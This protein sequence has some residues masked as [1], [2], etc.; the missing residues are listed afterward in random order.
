VKRHVTNPWPHTSRTASAVFASTDS[1]N[2]S[3]RSQVMALSNV[4]DNTPIATNVS[5]R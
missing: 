4:S 2:C 1:W 5:R 3:K